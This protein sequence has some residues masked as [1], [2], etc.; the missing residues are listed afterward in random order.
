MSRS[1]SFT[2][3]GRTQATG[4]V[5]AVVYVALV[6]A[7]I[8]LSVTFWIIA[9]LFLFTVPAIWDLVKN[10]KSGMEITDAA[11][12]WEHGKNSATIQKPEIERIRVDLRLDRSVK[13]T[14][15]MKTGRKIRVTQPSIPPLAQLEQALQ[16][17][18]YA[19]QKNP[20]SLL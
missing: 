13:L 8:F 3:A 5:L 19:Y 2:R 18:G 9:G 4:I 14:L 16:D 12:S 7:L 6:A 10:P 15:I 17:H 11:I 20:F 1:F